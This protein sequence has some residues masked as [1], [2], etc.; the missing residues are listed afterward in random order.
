MATTA[1]PTSMESEDPNSA[2]VS[3][4]ASIFSTARSEVSSQPT[5]AALYSSPEVRSALISSAPEI[6]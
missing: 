1:S 2:G 3:P 5:I 4:S 6:T